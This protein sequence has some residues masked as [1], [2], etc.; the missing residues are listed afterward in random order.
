MVKDLSGIRWEAD[1]GSKLSEKDGTRGE[2]SLEG[3]D[4]SRVLEQQVV[5]SCT[6]PLSSLFIDLPEL[7]LRGVEDALLNTNGARSFL[8]ATLAS[9]IFG[10]FASHS[11]ILRNSPHR[12]PIDRFC[13]FLPSFSSLFFLSLPF[14]S[15]FSPR[16]SPLH[17]R[18]EI[19]YRHL[20]GNFF[21]LFLSL[22]S[23]FLSLSCATSRRMHLT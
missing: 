3:F 17:I 4:Y 23:A 14:P 16:L 12:R 20:L 1:S 13:F 11:L 15:T 19:Y 21:I 2:A 8:R 6:R 22:S 5:A 7:E 18:P 9:P 10:S